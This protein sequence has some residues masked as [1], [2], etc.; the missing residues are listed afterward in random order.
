[1]HRGGKSHFR[2]HPCYQ[3]N[4]RAAKAIGLA[5]KNQLRQG[6]CQKL[7][8]KIDMDNNWFLNFEISS[9]C[10]DRKRQPLSSNRQNYKI[11]L[12]QT[13]LQ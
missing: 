12:N 10:F 5:W 3:L 4:W 9:M 1:M 13:Q 7:Q 6:Q 8:I 11:Y 2:S